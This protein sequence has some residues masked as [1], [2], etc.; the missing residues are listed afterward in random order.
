MERRR[1]S[2]PAKVMA[3]LCVDVSVGEGEDGNLIDPSMQV[4]GFLVPVYA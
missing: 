1:T 4:C 3:L 2:F